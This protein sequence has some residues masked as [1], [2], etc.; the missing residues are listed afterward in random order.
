MTAI[1]NP[2]AQSAMEYLMTYGWAILI[3]SVV[4]GA[5]FSLG[6]FS[7]AGLLGTACIA[8]SGFLCSS[9]ILAT[10]GNITFSFGQSTGITLYNIAM[11]CV[12]TTTTTGLPGNTVAMV[13]LSAT[14][15]ATTTLSSPGNAGALTLVSGQTI[16]VNALKCF[17]S[18]PGTPGLIN[19]ALGTSFS[20]SLLMNYTAA[21]GAPTSGVGS[22]NPL[23]T[24]KI[25]ALTTKV[26]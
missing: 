8:G 22:T 7:G 16:T 15:G 3:I 13:L 14:G 24:S 9:P 20:G 21:T 25:A 2:K 26:V 10:N 18:A 5:L 12:A 1:I 6:V 17:G 11:A 19:Q 23:L 4:L